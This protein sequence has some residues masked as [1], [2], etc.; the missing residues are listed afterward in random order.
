MPR[1]TD[2]ERL[3][4]LQERQSKIK[5]A[6]DKLQ[7]KQRIA[8]RRKARINTSRRKIIAGAVVLKYVE[9][10][11]ESDFA[12]QF[13]IM[14]DRAVQRAEDRALFDFPPLDAEDPEV[15][16]PPDDHMG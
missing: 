2:A 6:I 8:E 9:E 15:T 16:P 10:N 13:E 14:I 7:A 5:S 1:L 11:P 4:R 3:A 12:H